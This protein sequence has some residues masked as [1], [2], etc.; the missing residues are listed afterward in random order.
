MGNRLSGGS[1]ARKSV[2]MLMLFRLLVLALAGSTLTLYAQQ[3]SGAIVGTV[4]D[5]TGAAIPGATIIIINTATNATT[6]ATSSG[7]GE[8]VAAQLPVG[9]YEIHVKQGN[10]KE[11][12][13]TGV[14]VHTST[15]TKVTAVL[16]VGGTSERV[17]VTA[18]ALQVQT[19]SAV[20]GEVVSGTQVRE[21]PLNGENF[22]GLTQLSPG[23]SAAQGAN[24][25]G[26]GL[27]GGV[28]FSVNG[29]PY[30][31]NLFLVDGV[32]N[33]DVGSNRTILIYPAVDTIAEFKMLR[34]SYGPE[35]GQASGAIISLTTRSGANQFHGGAFYAGR[36][37]AL[38][39]NNWFANHE[40][41]GKAEER[42]HDYGYNISGPAIKDKLFFWWNQ[43]WN[44]E[45]QGVP[46][47]ACVP[48]SA[49]SA[50]DFSGYSG[51]TD[52]CGATLPTIPTYAQAPGNPN[53]I[54]SPDAAG[55]LIAQFYPSP[56]NSNLIA[57]NNYNQL[58]RNHLN[59]SEWNVRG[60]YDVTKSNRATL[61]W[62]QDS[63]DNPSQNDGTPFWGEANF[64]TVD[65]SW[66]QPSKS[67]MAKLSSV[68]SN[69][70]VND[71]EFGYGH[72]AIITTLQGT[73]ASIVPAL[74]T[75][76]PATFPA[77]LKEKDAFFGAWGGL[78]PYG[79]IGGNS[80]AG[81]NTT[82]MWNIAPY[83]N[84]E[85]L[86]TVQDNLSKVHG[87]HLFKAGVFYGNNIKVE[88]SGNGADRPSLPGN[89]VAPLCAQTNNNL[90][91]VLLPGTGANAQVFTGI[92]ENSIDQT[93]YVKWH[94]IEWYLGDTWKLRRNLTV[95]YGFRWSFYREPYGDNNEWANFSPS[96]W[97]SA[98]AAANPSD[99]CN[100]TQIVPGTSPCAKQR[101]F[102]ATLGVNLPLS[103]GTPG[104]NRALV[105][106]NN[107]AIAPR[108][109]IAWDV[110]G[111]G[112]TAVRVGAGQFFQRELVGIAENLAKTAPFVLGI[113]TNRSL[114]T[115]TPLSSASVS[116][117]ANKT[118]G[119]NIPNAW[120]WNLS[121]EQ[122]VARN[123]TLQIGYV[124]N[125]GIHLTSM[126]DVNPVPA[127]NWLAGAFENGPALNALRPAYNF[128]TVGGFARGGHASYNSL[129]VLFRAQTGSFSTFQAAYTWSHSVGNVELD[130]SSGNVNQ[131]AITDQDNPRLDKGNT[132]INRPNIFVANEVLFLPKLA[133]SN[134]LVKNVFG[135]WEFNSIF[136]AAQGSSLTVFS[137]GGSGACTNLDSNGNCI[138]GYASTL[139]ALVGTGLDLNGSLG[140]NLRPLITQM[141]CSEGKSG[142]NLVNW[143]HFSLMG[144]ALGTFPSNL[145][146]RG[147]CYGAPNTNMDAQL[148]KNWS[149]KEKL[150]IKFSMD[151]FN[152][153]NHPN[154]NSGNLEGTGFTSGSPLLCGG[155]QQA[156][157]GGGPTGQPCSPTNNIIT[158]S[159]S[160]SPT[161]PSS[162][163]NTPT[164]FA[165]AG[166]Q[167]QNLG[168]N[169]QYTLRF[170]F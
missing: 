59:W 123:T 91:N 41:L 25:V 113:N 50:G 61:R 30:T 103:N 44:K 29:N 97:S 118:T 107:H 94:D 131:Q 149:V 127:A 46:F 71:V 129:Q 135:S 47:G 1:P 128:S 151:F 92:G 90:A 69:S 108:V 137:A 4:T 38:N 53:K 79:Y 166:S 15:N 72:N 6:T 111:D 36:N 16:E 49:E 68:I 66:S 3:Y 81:S 75:A 87:N 58:I 78:N 146:P 57:G 73:R 14:E 24:F 51:P 138:E 148:A 122:Q 8:F 17:T 65:S 144:Y 112:K 147:A 105:D 19:T 83:G 84:H 9:A 100:G 64:P 28:N 67:V 63:W 159:A 20:V 101:A 11:Y 31:N 21:L 74:Q 155:A 5:Q 132:N 88:D 116:P 23:V 39:A 27:D 143:Q 98:E 54:A 62:T 86:Y 52:Q 82:S 18:T 140:N 158:G 133:N 60:D 117:N 168:R 43:E 42:R 120:Q 48:T 130:N 7:Q 169:L 95:D 33:N 163:L 157:P 70:M 22:V 13:E 152:L 139:S 162:R 12:V 37:D 26:K 56:T 10:F 119:G 76:Y 80:G 161:N 32:N 134:A 125:T 89:C 170:T 85:D 156:V 121:V 115:V 45:I 106:Q 34:N 35:Y 96:A 99:A 114:D 93:A 160:G 142:P 141:S 77:S 145:A 102:L 153:F 150:R 110:R 136:T 167:N 109:G 104:P 154:F 126:R 124:G 40:D 164:G 55:L 165:S 2:S